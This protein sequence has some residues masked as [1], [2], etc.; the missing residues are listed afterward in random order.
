MAYIPNLWIA[1]TAAALLASLVHVLIDFH[2]GLYGDTSSRMSSLQ[3]ANLFLTSLVYGWWIYA[4]GVAST[5][6]KSAL[7]SA[8]VIVALWGLLWNGV[9][10][11][12]VSPPA[13]QR[14]PL[15]DIAHVSCIVFGAGASA[16][17]W[18]AS[19]SIDT[20][21]SWAMPIAAGVVLL[22]A[23]VVQSVLGLQN[24]Q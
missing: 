16:A 19:R 18:R 14:V 17:I 23:F 5:G 22:S 24:T 8:L 13:Q 9:V 1:W 11:L 20:E 6:N 12:A 3:A 4:V 10:G 2:L 21:V 15:Q 7:V